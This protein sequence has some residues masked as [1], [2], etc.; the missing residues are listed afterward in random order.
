MSSYSNVA[1]AS[2]KELPRKTILTIINIAFNN[3]ETKFARHLAYYWLDFYP[4]DLDM[5]FVVAK[6]LLLEGDH[7]K[8][9]QLLSQILYKDPTHLD[10]INE[11]IQMCKQH[12]YP[13]LL[14]YEGLKYILSNDSSESLEEWAQ[15]AK[16]AFEF[17]T[18]N[19][20]VTAI[21][22]IQTVFGAICFHSPAFNFPFDVC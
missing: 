11:I 7:K 21:S 15:T 10:A 16:Q 20:K 12:D 1:V 13:N 17:Y 4:G 14:V 22:L 9:H 3:N 6:S 18:N 5:Q 2:G 8:A 19:D